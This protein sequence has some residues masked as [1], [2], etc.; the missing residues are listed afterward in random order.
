MWWQVSALPSLLRPR[1]G[2]LMDACCASRC[3]GHLC[4]SA[5]SPPVYSQKRCPGALWPVGPPA[6]PPDRLPPFCI[7]QRPRGPNLSTPSPAL[8]T[9]CLFRS[10]ET[11]S[12]GPPRGG[13]SALT[14][15]HGRFDA[16]FSTAARCW[17]SFTRL[18]AVCVSS[19]DQCLFGSSAH[20]LG[21]LSCVCYFYESEGLWTELEN[22]TARGK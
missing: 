4:G 7:Q 3:C 15:P 18:P 20:S 5:F 1:K 13:P 16:H 17:A 11:K 22:G 12:E 6:A 21:S 9:T 14:L 8:V 2:H 10:S 19:W